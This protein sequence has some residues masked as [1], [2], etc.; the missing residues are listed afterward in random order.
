M[1]ENSLQS[2]LDRNLEK[3]SPESAFH[4]RPTHHRAMTMIGGQF[5]YAISRELAILAAE[6]GTSKRALL[7]EALDLLFAKR[8]R[9]SL[10]DLSSQE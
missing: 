6:E 10:S 4:R 2:V 9:P 1:S 3:S 5:D 8:G 7:A